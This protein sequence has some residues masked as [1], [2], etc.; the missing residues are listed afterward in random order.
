LVKE[1]WVR[2]QS[3][4]VLLTAIHYLSSLGRAET[5]LKYRLE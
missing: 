1:D 3:R 2:E 5:K 4:R